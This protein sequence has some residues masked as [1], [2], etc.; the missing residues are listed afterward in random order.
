MRAKKGPAAGACVGKRY[1][2]VHP[3]PVWESLVNRC[4]QMTVEVCVCGDGDVRVQTF[5]FA[6]D[7]LMID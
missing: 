4:W 7:Y 5:P 1:I 6:V 2:H 3:G